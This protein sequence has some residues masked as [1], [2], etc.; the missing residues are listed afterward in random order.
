MNQLDWMGFDPS[1]KRNPH[2]SDHTHHPGHGGKRTPSH[3]DHNQH[4]NQ[5]KPCNQLGEH[6]VVLL[7]AGIIAQ[8]V[9][10]STDFSPVHADNHQTTAA[11]SPKTAQRS[12]AGYYPSD[13]QTVQ[14]WQHPPSTQQSS[15]SF[16]LV[17]CL[18]ECYSM[19]M[20]CCQPL[21]DECLEAHDQH[22]THLLGA[23]T[24]LLDPLIDHLLGLCHVRARCQQMI[25]LLCQ[26]EGAPAIHVHDI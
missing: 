3:S 12:A 25:L 24:V 21:V 16:G 11:Q 23:N 15:S 4:R 19:W 5:K 14:E 8:S 6:G 10:V 22:L 1:H 17:P 2:H 9:R 20:V 18:R 7:Y 13:R 26:S